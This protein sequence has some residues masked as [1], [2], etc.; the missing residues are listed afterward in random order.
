[1]SRSNPSPSFRL[2]ATWRASDFAAAAK[3]AAFRCAAI[4]DTL[5]MRLMRSAVVGAARAESV[6]RR[7]GAEARR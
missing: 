7:A 1:M 5:A 6:I 3:L 2:R 4:F